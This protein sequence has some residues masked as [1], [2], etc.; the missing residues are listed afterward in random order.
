VERTIGYMGY[1][2]LSVFSPATNCCEILVNS[3]LPIPAILGL[4]Y[5]TWW[6]IRKPLM[7]TQKSP[8]LKNRYQRMQKF[9][10]SDTKSIDFF[11]R[12]SEWLLG[13]HAMETYTVGTINIIILR[14]ES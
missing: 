4:S 5:F 9:S 3:T 10:A 6:V 2:P 13:H 7:F 1:Q 14:L 11:S 8:L 12:K